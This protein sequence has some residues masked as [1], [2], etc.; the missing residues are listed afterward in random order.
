M[1]D[2]SI[3]KAIRERRK[4]L[5]HTQAWMA[6][7]LGIEER[8]YK[9][10]ES[11]GGT[12]LLYGRMEEIANLLNVPLSELIEDEEDKPSLLKDERSAFENMV[13][14]LRLEIVRLRDDVEKLHREV[15]RLNGCI[16]DKDFII[17]HLRTQLAQFGKDAE[18]EG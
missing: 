4:E 7:Q 16:D 17:R 2:N 13:S 6:E 9:L 12:R 15:N 18:K 1:N 5:G 11:Y 8:T 3:K 10:V 14:D